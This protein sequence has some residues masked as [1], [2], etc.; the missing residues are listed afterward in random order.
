MK[1]KT[2]ILSL[3]LA[4]T[5]LVGLIPATAIGV[6]ADT[7]EFLG[8]EG[9]NQ[10]NG[11]R[12]GGSGENTVNAAVIDTT[13][14][15]CKILGISKSTAEKFGTTIRASLRQYQ[16][17]VDIS[18]LNIKVDTS[19]SRQ[20]NAFRAM[21]E[22][23]VFYA[24]D[25]F[26]FKQTTYRWWN[27]SSNQVTRVEFITEKLTYNHNQYQSNLASVLTIAEHLMEGVKGNKNLSD[28]QK[29]L[30]L[31]DRLAAW[32][33]YDYDNQQAGTC[34]DESYS[35]VGVLWHKVGVCQGYSEAYAY[36]LDQCGIPNR[37]AQSTALN[38]IWNIVTIGGKEY[39]VDVTWDDPAAYDRYGQ[40]THN[41][42]LVSMEKL[43]QDHNATD[44][45]TIPAGV[46]TYDT[47]FWTESRSEFQLVDGQIYYLD[48]VVDQNVRYA[49]LCKWAAG[50]T[51]PLLNLNNDATM[52]WTTATG[53][54][55]TSNYS[56]LDSWNGKLYVTDAKQV[57]EYDPATAQWKAV[58]APAL[59]GNQCL[60]GF[61]IHAGRYFLNLYDTMP[62]S[63][64]QHKAQQFFYQPKDIRSIEVI[65]RP[66]QY[67][68]QVG[69]HYDF[70]GIT[71]K[72][73]YT[74]GTSDTV[75]NVLTAWNGYTSAVAGELTFTA[76]L[77][78]YSDDF[79]IR[80]VKNLST[81]KV[82]AKNDDKG[83][84]VSW[85]KVS[86]A[87]EYIVYRSYQSGGKWSSWS[88]MKVT[89]GTSWTDTKAKDGKLYRYAVYAYHV[90]L[91]SALGKSS[92]ICRLDT[93]TVTVANAKSGTYLSWKKVTGATSY[94]IYRSYRKGST[95]TEYKKIGTSKT[96]TYT[97]KKASSNTYYRY[98]VKAVKSSYSSAGSSAKSIRRLTTV[99]PTA[100][101][102][103]STIKVSW[104]KVTGAKHY[105]VY[106]RL[107]GSST[108]TKIAT[109]KTLSY[110]DKTA[111]KGKYY[112]YSVRGVEGSSYGAHNASKKVKR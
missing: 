51:Y 64:A 48:N 104:K 76:T 21:L 84:K 103:G 35:M 73:N 69:D 39:Y 47:Y 20:Y 58:F 30:L 14:D 34:P 88:K 74:D 36:M 41:Y 90:N 95:W 70:R 79:T 26:M 10:V 15:Y 59:S 28:M 24:F 7:A 13:V 25:V 98:V 1:L 66:T 12:I 54:I 106:R 57:Y 112:E 105:A 9:Q 8:G 100:K 23:E 78:N 42:F 43:R 49:T 31:H 94:A 6:S 85:G 72:V 62:T 40:V 45:S 83:V 89:T 33:Q 107:S 87:T 52:R 53:A 101:K 60:Y 44:Y 32:T 93:P 92:T 75:T 16:F 27:T 96:T 56:T 3:L 5:L 108:W 2:R 29:A 91:R 111:K 4:V 80:I 110:T 71:L 38:H 11:D 81:P 37:F 55:Y 61:T 46:T 22:H 97:D 18:S 82:T 77:Y 109:T 17:D 102:S 99:T 65:K 68:Y 67:V 86:Y 50:A 63:Q 19:N